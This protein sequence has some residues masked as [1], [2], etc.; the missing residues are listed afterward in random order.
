LAD[1]RASTAEGEGMDLILELAE[2]GLLDHDGLSVQ[3]T[4][5]DQS[6][7]HGSRGQ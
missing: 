7:F 5:M 2:G 6:V 3:V 4:G 1:V